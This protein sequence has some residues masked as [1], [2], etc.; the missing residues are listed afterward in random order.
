MTEA[1]DSFSEFLTGYLPSVDEMPRYLCTVG[2]IK[3]IDA[4]IVAILTALEISRSITGMELT[5]R[6]AYRNIL[7]CGIL[8]GIDWQKQIETQMHGVA[9]DV[10]PSNLEPRLI[11]RCC[12]SGCN[13]PGAWKVETFTDVTYEGVCIDH[14][15]RIENRK[16]VTA[17]IA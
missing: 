4:E 9:K 15:R 10:E 11:K 17:T 16:T 13:S 2:A 7:Q 12:F 5:N 3:V 1:S 14:A 6:S 8:I